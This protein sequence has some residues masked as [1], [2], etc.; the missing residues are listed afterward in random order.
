MKKPKR[1]HIDVPLQFKVRTKGERDS[2]RR[3]CKRLRISFSAMAR[4]A[5]LE[6]LDRLEAEA[7]E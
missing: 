7:A 1:D 3:R 6:K 4:A 2:I 5:V